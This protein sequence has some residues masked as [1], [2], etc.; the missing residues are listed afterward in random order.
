M[1]VPWFRALLDQLDKRHPNDFIAARLTAYCLELDYSI[2]RQS[3]RSEPLD[4][5]ESVLLQSKS[6]RA[7]KAINEPQYGAMLTCRL[8]PRPFLSEPRPP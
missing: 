2:G 5:L 7:T 1:P 3:M 6:H 8:L 4:R